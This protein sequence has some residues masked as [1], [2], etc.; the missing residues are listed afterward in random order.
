MTILTTDVIDLIGNDPLKSDVSLV[1]TDHL[2]WDN[3]PHEHLYLIQEKLNKY[4]SYIESG[5]FSNSFPHFIEKS[6][7][8]ELVLKF[9]PPEHAIVILGKFS[10]IVEN[11]GFKF[12][13][14]L[15]NTTDEYF[16]DTQN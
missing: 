16:N 12:V 8:I 13:W 9:H 15:L 2:T 11:A 10:E 6:I 1:M 7:L 5:E 4:L 3:D 14:R